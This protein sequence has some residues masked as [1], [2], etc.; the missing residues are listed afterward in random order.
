MNWLEGSNQRVFWTLAVLV[1]GVA[2]AVGFLLGSGWSPDQGPAQV[3]GPSAATV[4]ARIE[5]VLEQGE[6]TVAGQEQTFQVWRVRILQGEQRG[7][8]Y[9]VEYGARSPVPVEVELEPGDEILVSLGPGPEGETVAFFAD[10]VR[11]GPLLLLAGA[12]VVLILVVSGMKGLR[13]IVG[14]AVSFA[15]IL[16][17]ILPQILAGR[18]P[19]LVSIVGSFGLLASTMYIVYGWSLKTHTAVLGTLLALVM[20]GLLAT[21]FVDL[22]LLT[23]TGAEETLFLGQFMTQPLNV[24]GLLLGAMIIGALGVLDDLT[25]SQVSAVFELRRA[26]P[27]L[28]ARDLFQRAMVIGRDHVAAT[29][30]TLV[31]AYV[32]A[33]LPLLLLFTVLGEPFA[34]VVNRSVV[35]EEIVRTLVGSLGLVAAVPVTTGIAS[36]AAAWSA[37]GGQLPGWLGP[38]LEDSGDFHGHSH[39]METTLPADSSD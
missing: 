26:N 10:F 12:F 22:T 13:G 5:A 34:V 11:T 6:V 2:V 28:E 38:G 3:T 9:V 19:V 33:S 18:D 14:M 32:G 30:N 24:R 39:M 4:R 37:G 29:V 15:V 20:T 36:W 31:L 27:R 1:I 8:E 35:A 25:I 17:F 21:T 23:G 16:F 7:E